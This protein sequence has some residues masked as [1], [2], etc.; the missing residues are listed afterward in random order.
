MRIGIV[1]GGGD[2]PGLNAVIRAVAKAA[3]RRGWEAIGIVNGFEGL[4]EPR[5]TLALDRQALAGLLIRGGTILGTANRGRFSAKTGFGTER[6]LPVELLD[7]TREGTRALALDAL[8]VIGGDGSLSIALQLHKHGVPVVGVP[9][10]IDNDVG[11]TALTFGFVS[12]V[13]CVTSA[14]DRLHTTAESHR[15]VMV[16]EVMGRFAG[17]IA[18]YGGIAGGADVILIPEIP[19]RYD[20]VVEKIRARETEGRHFT[21]VVVAEGAH[22][23]DR[24]YV[25]SAEQ[26]ANREARLGGVGAVVAEEIATRTGKEVRTCVLGHLQRGGAP[27]PFDRMLCSM[28]GTEAI[29]L[30][31]AGAFGEMVAFSGTHV[32]AVPLADA[33]SKLRTVPPDGDM[34]RT[35]RA[36]GIC[37]GC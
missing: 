4:L 6:D 22:E 5:Q 36:L 10:T 13:D 30:V 37:L 33:V 26:A 7:A 8:V 31:A 15:R 9:K 21:M 1:T 27:S 12:A 16:V 34:A 2:C 17:W 19:F 3:N 11:G 35:A 18:L 28:F 29:Q 32:V 23:H 20:S 14:I 25:T 24:G